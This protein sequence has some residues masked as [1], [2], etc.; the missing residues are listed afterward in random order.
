MNFKKSFIPLY[1]TKIVLI[2]RFIDL[3][4]T[5]LFVE[6]EWKFFIDI[7][8]VGALRR[9]DVAVKKESVTQ[10]RNYK[11]P[12]TLGPATR[13]SQQ[14]GCHSTTRPGNPPSSRNVSPRTGLLFPFPCSLREYSPQSRGW[15][16]R[17]CS[18]P[19]GGRWWSRWGRRPASRYQC[20]PVDDSR[21]RERSPHDQ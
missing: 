1:F 9:T 10:L 3:S 18:L 15:P 7:V 12:L 16:V 8:K 4:A 20:I 2:I 17:G 14:S 13:P 21:Q 11:T 19:W 6:S 5:S